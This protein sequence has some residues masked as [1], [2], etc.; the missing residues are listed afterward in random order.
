LSEV[1]E[2]VGG[3]TSGSTAARPRD[4]LGQ[5]MGG[6]ARRAGRTPRSRRI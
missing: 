3:S 5:V 4:R 1:A 2:A 6:R